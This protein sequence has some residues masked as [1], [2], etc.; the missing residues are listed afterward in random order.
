MKHLIIVLIMLFAVNMSAQRLGVYYVS[1]GGTENYSRADEFGAQ[2]FLGPK[3]STKGEW[4]IGLGGQKAE[5]E[6]Y[7]GDILK[8]TAVS[9]GRYQRGPKGWFVYATGYFGDENGFGG[10]GGYRWR[11]FGLSS[12][13]N[14]IGGLQVGF[15]LIMDW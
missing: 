3:D 6:D 7:W 13:Y 8:T 1:Q 12:G 4:M 11:W 9:L 10:T 5:P 2:V 14:S 15:H